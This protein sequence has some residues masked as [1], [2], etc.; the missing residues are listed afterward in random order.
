MMQGALPP[1]APPG[2]DWTYLLDQFIRRAGPFIGFLIVV[3]LG[4]QPLRWV[5]GS[6]V[7]AAL[8]ERIRTR[9]GGRPSVAP[10]DSARVIGERQVAQLHEQ[11]SELAERLDFA[12]RLLAERR[13]R[14]LGAGQ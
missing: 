11:V 10:D 2:T 12:E 8:A 13:E 14:T 7:G 3:V 1:M 4:A 9:G 6:P 5:L